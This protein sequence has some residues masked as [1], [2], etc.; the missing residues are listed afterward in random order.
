MRV[1]LTFILAS[2]CLLSYGQ[3]F[4]NKGKEFW[5][6]YGYND[7]MG[8][9][10]QDMVVYLS[11]DQPANVTVSVSGTSWV[12]TYSIAA[13]QVVVTDAIPKTGADDCRITGEG[14]YKKA[15]HIESDVPIVAYAH[16]YGV[17]SSGAAMLLPVETYGY[18]YVSC[19]PPQAYELGN[20]A[21]D[22]S[23]FYVVAAENN[24]RVRITPINETIS[25]LIPTKSY[26]VIL[27]KGEM[28]NVMGKATGKFGNNMSGSRIVSIAGADG[29]C[30]PISVFSGSSRTEIDP[31]QCNVLNSSGDFI[32]QQVFPATAWGSRYLAGITASNLGPDKP[33]KNIFRIFVRDRLTNVY[34][35]GSL[36]SAALTDTS[37]YDVFATEPQYITAD[38]PI[39]VAQLMR[40]QDECVPG[41]KGDPEMIFLSPMEQAIKNVSFYSAQKENILFN[42]VTL[43]IHQ[44][45][46]SSLSIDG[47]TPGDLTS[48]NVI[49]HPHLPGYKVV[50]REFPAVGAQ[51][52]V[53]SDSGFN[54]ITYGYGQYESYGYNAGCYINNLTYISEIK[55]DSSATP[56]TYT[57]PKT[58]FSI[59]IKTLYPVTG[60]IWNYGQ[61]PGFLPGGNIV[62]SNP[63]PDGTEEVN[64]VVY[65]VYKQPLPALAPA[66]GT[67]YIP[68][69]I[70]S[71]HIDNCTNSE[72]L[73]VEVKVLPGPTADFTVTPVCATKMNGFNASSPDP[74]IDKWRWE[75]GDK[76]FDDV[77][78]PQKTYAAGGTYN[79]NMWAFRSSDGCAGMV[80]KTV[81]IPGMPKAAFDPPA[82]VCMPN[83]TA[84]FVNKTTVPGVF[85]GTLQ[86]AWNF[87]DNGTATDKSP[88]H[89]YATPGSYPAKLVV[90]TN[91][92][93]TDSIT[94][95]IATF[96][97]RPVAGIGVT[98]PEQCAGTAFTF[99]DKSIYPGTTAG[100]TWK[101]TYGDGTTGT[102]ASPAK[103][104]KQ[105]NSYTVTMTVTSNEGCISDTASTVVKIYPVPTVD[106]GPDLIT[107]PGKSILLQASVTPATAAITWSPATSLSS[108]SQLQPFATPV[109]TQRYYITATGDL[110]CSG[111]DSMLLK[112]FKE[113]K[114][115]NAFTPNGDGKND[116]WKIPGLEDYKNATVQ[117]F[118]RWGQIVFK[119][120]GYSNPW[121]GDIN[122]NPLPT[123]A[124]YYVIQPKEGGYGTIS[125][126][127][128]IVR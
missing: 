94:A 20:G 92:G 103:T 21:F 43:T 36:T 13:G 62:Y 65:N 15:V 45:G 24:T 60:I 28:F 30:H 22:Y 79:V 19:N 120:T 102:G 109:E 29:K 33:N 48:Y 25:G 118:N 26:D 123:G 63:V 67:Y 108:P 10:T 56:N 104:Y 5:V 16:M 41:T 125:G 51:H 124:Y 57:C 74:L 55:N 49:D 96:G 73:I 42:G 126:T 101:W 87:G 14:T 59:N 64:G 53:K 122:G 128:L 8:A 88:T 77:M 27:N 72:N 12:R 46:L 37:Y 34:V 86:Y 58:P 127:V 98:K 82:V 114:V 61:L 18:T 99:S 6:G 1:I 17:N 112:V 90:T 91:Q 106:A 111:T 81:T 76:T 100:A 44:N 116:T 4:T 93:C 121:R 110:G 119:S 23:W 69:T 78:A 38:K 66:I 117:V 95:T 83:G 68:I 80:T 31:N 71:P 115:P 40:S 85:T 107:E 32:M 39:M 9:N 97:E 89:Y 3:N 47:S 54:A 7:L 113:L 2:A 11:A 70:V 50:F 75:F 84:D 105:A 52:T 35:N